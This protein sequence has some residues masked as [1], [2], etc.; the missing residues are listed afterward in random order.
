M[1]MLSCLQRVQPLGGGGGG[2]GQQQQHVNAFFFPPPISEEI[3]ITTGT[4][5][6]ADICLSNGVRGGAVVGRKIGWRT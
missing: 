3:R 1:R 2:G 5:V 4:A 6:T